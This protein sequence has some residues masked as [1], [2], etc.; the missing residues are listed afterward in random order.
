MVKSVVE[1]KNKVKWGR[2]LVWLEEPQLGLCYYMCRANGHMPI[3]IITQICCLVSF[4]FPFS[5]ISSNNLHLRSAALSF[6]EVFLQNF[7]TFLFMVY[8]IN[9]S[10][11]YL[12]LFVA[13]KK[14]G[15][16]WW[17]LLMI[18]WKS[19]KQDNLHKYRNVMHKAASKV[20]SRLLKITRQAWGRNGVIIPVKHGYIPNFHTFSCNLMIP[21]VFHSDFKI[22]SI[23]MVQ[24]IESN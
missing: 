22:I 6:M 3:F 17:A 10:D 16:I 23:W 14:E 7:P 20:S 11:L 15:R 9:W 18:T 2:I 24:L 19:P 4:F 21:D 8:Y 13:K 1:A 12:Y 5:V